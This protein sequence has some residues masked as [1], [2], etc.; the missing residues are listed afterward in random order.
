MWCKEEYV[1]T[2][3]YRMQ[4]APDKLNSWTEKWCVAVNKDKFSNTLFTLS[5]KQKAGIIILGGTPLKADEATYLGVTFDKRQAWK[6][7]IAKAEAKARRMLAILRK[8][9][10][11]EQHGNNVSLSAKKTLIRSLT[12]PR[13]QRDDYDPCP[14]SSKSFW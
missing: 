7:H 4:L 3:T 6:Q 2:A 9:A 13:S 14:G 8:G 11:G 5:P 1:T 12:M 10:R